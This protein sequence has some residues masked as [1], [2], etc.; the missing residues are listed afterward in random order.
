[1]LGLCH[2]VVKIRALRDRWPFW[3]A[4]FG[5]FAGLPSEDLQQH[6]VIYLIVLG[7]AATGIAAMLFFCEGS[8][9][10]KAFR[11][12]R[13]D[14]LLAQSQGI[15]VSASKFCASGRSIPALAVP[16]YAPASTAR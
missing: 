11:A 14:P 15:N 4:C 3:A 12:F 9:A 13:K 16:V 10:G 2:W 6:A 1:M 5:R 7:F 8:N